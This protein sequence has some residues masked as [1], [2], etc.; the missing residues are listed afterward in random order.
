MEQ[1]HEIDRTLTA[2][3]DTTPDGET[4][5][6]FVIMVEETVDGKRYF[7]Y[8]CSGNGAL[9]ALGI[10]NVIKESAPLR[11]AFSLAVKGVEPNKKKR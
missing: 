5:S 1:I 2:W 4:R 6:Y 3:K 11:A 7:N 8:G 10:K 9:L